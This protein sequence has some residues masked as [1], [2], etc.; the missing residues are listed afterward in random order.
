M[1]GNGACNLP[2]LH[3]NWGCRF[4]IRVQ[5]L[6]YEENDEHFS[7]KKYFGMASLVEQC[8]DFHGLQKGACLDY[9]LVSINC[10][11]LV[12]VQL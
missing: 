7:E 1:G 6:K 9:S 4:T 3:Y 12:L 11:L 2:P 5:T 8:G 10:D